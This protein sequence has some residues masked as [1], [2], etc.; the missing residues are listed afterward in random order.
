MTADIRQVLSKRYSITLDQVDEVM[1]VAKASIGNINAICVPTPHGTAQAEFMRTRWTVRF[2]GPEE[3]DIGNDGVTDMRLHTAAAKQKERSRNSVMPLR[4]ALEFCE[5][6]N[7]NRFVTSLT[8]F[9]QPNPHLVRFDEALDQLTV[10]LTTDPHNIIALAADQKKLAQVLYA[11]NS[12]GDP[13]T[14]LGKYGANAIARKITD[15]IQT[16]VAQVTGRDQ[17]TAVAVY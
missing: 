9:A 16:A 3:K 8:A 6:P 11:P 17:A 2:N 10:T 1:A 13:V 5:Q 15:Y 12:S 14:T 7:S 4:E